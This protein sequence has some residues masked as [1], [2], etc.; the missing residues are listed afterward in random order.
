VNLP[1]AYRLNGRPR[2]LLATAKITE[3]NAVTL[4]NGFEPLIEVLKAMR[5][6][7][8]EHSVRLRWSFS[9]RLTART[10]ERASCIDD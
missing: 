10:S 4:V 2:E 7:E 6:P 9:N 1:I 5:S 8:G 3:E